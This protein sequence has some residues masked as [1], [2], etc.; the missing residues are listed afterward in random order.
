MDY[1][2]PDSDE[3]LQDTSPSTNPA[4]LQAALWCQG[5]IIRTY[6]VEVEMLKAT[7]QQLQQQAQNQ[8]AP[9]S[10]ALP[11]CSELPRF[12]LP[13]TFDGSADCCHGYLH[14]CPETV[15]NRHY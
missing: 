14:Q 4:D 5:V 15:Q 12:A 3:S 2:L 13:E 9:P 10:P 7:N 8:A 1:N 11:P 6:Q